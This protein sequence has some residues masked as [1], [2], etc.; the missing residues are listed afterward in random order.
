M[1]SKM[2]DENSFQG[3]HA[4]SPPEV[5]GQG[6]NL[7]EGPNDSLQQT[8]GS[9]NGKPPVNNPG[10][11]IETT[12]VINP[13]G[14]GNVQDDPVLVVTPE[15]QRRSWLLEVSQSAEDNPE[16]VNSVNSD[17]ES[18]GGSWT[19]EDGPDANLRVHE[20]QIQNMMRISEALEARA[21]KAEREQSDN[22][23]AFKEQLNDAYFKHAESMQAQQ[24]QWDAER[25]E[26]LKIRKELIHENGHLQ[27][28]Y[29]GAC[30]QINGRT[31]KINDLDT[32]ISGYIE[33]LKLVKAPDGSIYI[34][35]ERQNT[36]DDLK[37]D[38]NAQREFYKNQIKTLENQVAR[39]V[40]RLNQGTE[41]SR[42]LQ[43]KLQ[44][45]STEL[46][47]E[48]QKY[49]DAEAKLELERKNHVG[50]E[51]VSKMNFERA[52]EVQVVL[53]HRDEQIRQ[54]ANMIRNLQA[55]LDTAQRSYA[56]AMDTAT[57]FHGAHEKSSAENR[58]LV[59]Q[60][61]RDMEL[62]VNDHKSVC[63][64]YSQN[65]AVL[66]EEVVMLK[67]MII[68]IRGSN[69]Y[70]WGPWKASASATGQE[71]LSLRA[72]LATAKDTSVKRDKYIA[73]PPGNPPKNQI[74]GSWAPETL[75]ALAEA[76]ANKMR[77]RLDK[78]KGTADD[79][80]EKRSR[81]ATKD[82]P[83]LPGPEFSKLQATFRKGMAE[84]EMDQGTKTKPTSKTMQSEQPTQP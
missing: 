57:N 13:S 17:N 67:T 50:M 16:T 18:D 19:F 58:E 68:S 81:G 24:E 26:A 80:V 79:I 77:M 53:G 51:E 38:A 20:L 10:C 8:V 63:N 46:S 32:R 31:E 84:A 14:D 15:W 47:N 76:Q 62:L 4:F 27:M 25:A 65:E 42:S 41:E 36:V 52:R 78:G 12:G 7:G 82:L 39:K 35:K 66:K 83:E 3:S 23:K 73:L 69:S 29:R 34:H 49:R 61:R 2:F 5:G 43:H 72:D 70:D 71:M 1:V 30:K 64:N 74:G 22:D 75:A 28:Q 54:M 21:R 55:H 45:L 33:V 9:D 59:R 40:A 44:A 11:D 56:E 48:Q 60:H 37:R 6:Q